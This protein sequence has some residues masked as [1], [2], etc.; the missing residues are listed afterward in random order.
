MGPNEKP[1]KSHLRAEKGNSAIP[2]GDLPL[3]LNVE[4]SEQVVPSIIVNSV[5]EGGWYRYTCRIA[6]PSVATRE[7]YDLRG[8]A[9]QGPSAPPSLI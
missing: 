8:K 5:K 2:E 1:S 9:E 7:D 3:H 6:R 4:E